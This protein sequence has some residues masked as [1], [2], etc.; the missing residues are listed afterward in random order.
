MRMIQKKQ[1]NNILKMFYKI[2][3]FN[4]NIINKN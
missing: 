4:N 1:I 3:I 2:K